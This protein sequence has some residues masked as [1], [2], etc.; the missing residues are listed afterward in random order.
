MSGEIGAE[1]IK[2]FDKYTKDKVKEGEYRLLLVH[3]HNSHYTV[4][5]LLYA[6][7]HLIIVFCYIPHPYSPRTRHC[8]LLS[9]QEIHWGG[10]QHMAT[11]TQGH[12]GQE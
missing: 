11:R 4:A 8:Y 5:F 6:H 3:G 7:E 9:T 1:W 12:Y 2:N 10:T